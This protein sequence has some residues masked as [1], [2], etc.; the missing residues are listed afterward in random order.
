MA[1]Y[2]KI[3]FTFLLGISIPLTLFFLS[4]VSPFNNDGSLSQQRVLLAI[5]FLSWVIFSTV[6][7]TMMVFIKGKQS[8]KYSAVITVGAVQVLLMLSVGLLSMISFISLMVFN[9]LFYWYISRRFNDSK[10]SL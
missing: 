10:S 7:L 9:A 4:Q 8:L 6:S 2:K 1:L 5:I 3:L